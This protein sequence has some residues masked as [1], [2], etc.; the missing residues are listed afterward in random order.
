M[1]PDCKTVGLRQPC[2][3][4]AYPRTGL[5]EIL[6]GAVVV[7]D[8]LAEDLAETKVRELRRIGGGDVSP[9]DKAASYEKA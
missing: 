7:D 2:S 8:V 5:S 1:D 4:Q 9:G 3:L 6:T